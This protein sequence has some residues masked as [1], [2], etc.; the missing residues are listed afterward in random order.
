MTDT[1]DWLGKSGKTHRYWFLDLNLPIKN[2]PGNYMFIKR[3][4]NGNWLPVYIGQA[5]SLRNHERLAEARLAGATH[6]MS[7]TTAGG[8]QD[9]LDEERD[10]IQYWDPPLNTHHRTGVK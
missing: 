2:E 1:I 8:E 7:H 6:A 10:L 4:P 5:D 9:R 3:L